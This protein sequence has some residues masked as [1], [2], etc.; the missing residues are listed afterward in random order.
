MKNHN[1]VIDGHSHFGN[2]YYHGFSDLNQYIENVKKNV[3][4][5]SLLMPTP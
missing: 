1:I 4:D 3:I 5:Y 2:D